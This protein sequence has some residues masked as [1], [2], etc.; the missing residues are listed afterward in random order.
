MLAVGLLVGERLAD[1]GDGVLVTTKQVQQF[2]VGIE[3]DRAVGLDL[4]RL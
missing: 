4:Y 3:I 1:D 2:G